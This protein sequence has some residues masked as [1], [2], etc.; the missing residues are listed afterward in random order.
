MATTHYPELRSLAPSDSRFIN[1][2]V[3]FD[4]E[5]LRPSYELLSG[6]PGSS[7]TFEIARKY[8]MSPYVLDRALSL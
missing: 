6:I 8:G 4:V 3:S 1:A 7:Y 2:S 5:T